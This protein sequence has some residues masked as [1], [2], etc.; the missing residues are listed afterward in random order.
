MSID[1]I[2]NEAL[3]EDEK[4]EIIADYL[5]GDSGKT[6]NDVTIFIESAAFEGTGEFDATE[7]LFDSLKD[8][9][10]YIASRGKGAVSVKGRLPQV[11][12]VG[13]W[14]FSGDEP[15]TGELLGDFYMIAGCCEYQVFSGV[16][17]AGEKVT[18]YFPNSYGDN[19]T[20]SQTTMV[21]VTK[22]E[23]GT[24]TGEY[25]TTEMGS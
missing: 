8:I 15:W 11:S 21:T 6:P 25:A 20:I 23:D 16:G 2:R 9:A 17:G 7:E 24:I 4:M 14:I 13:D 10:V 18:L 1:K 3:T 5:D 12:L 19:V 22:M